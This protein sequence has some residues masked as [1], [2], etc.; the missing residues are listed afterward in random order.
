MSLR[1][2]RISAIMYEKLDFSEEIK[3]RNARE[4]EMSTDLLAGAGIAEPKMFDI[5]TSLILKTFLLSC[6]V[7]KK[8]F[9]YILF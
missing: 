8:L 4:R 6:T 3:L 2:R 1:I 5:K 9:K 7:Y